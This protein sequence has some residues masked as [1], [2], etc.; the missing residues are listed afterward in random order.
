[1]LL[2][3]TECW[4]RLRK[5]KLVRSDSQNISDGS[6]N[7]VL[8]VSVEPS[9]AVIWSKPD[10]LDTAAGGEKVIEATDENEKG[11]GVAICDGSVHLLGEI[12]SED[13]ELLMDISDGNVIDINALAK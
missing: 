4:V 8:A 11:T 3:K 1:M 10:D 6:S 13:W 7:T 2:V 5:N 9:S 12:E